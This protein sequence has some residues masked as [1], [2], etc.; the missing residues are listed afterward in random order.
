MSH[1]CRQ[2]G[3]S[4]PLNRGIPSEPIRL[5]HD[6]GV[7]GF[8]LCRGIPPL[9]HL[10]LSLPQRTFFQSSLGG[11]HLLP[12]RPTHPH[13]CSSRHSLG[14]HSSG[15]RSLGQVSDEAR[16]S[17]PRHPNRCSTSTPGFS[18]WNADCF[19]EIDGLQRA[20]CQRSDFDV[21]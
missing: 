21:L 2:Y 9:P 7:S 14:P 10:Q 16:K 8:I 12:S 20:A 15:S 13:R 18:K 5:A 3:H 4:R 1:W 6:D 19:L 11:T 17:H